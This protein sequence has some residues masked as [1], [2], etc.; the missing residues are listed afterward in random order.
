MR[1]VNWWYNGPIILGCC[2]KRGADLEVGKISTPDPVYAGDVLT[3]TLVVTNNGPSVASGVFLVDPS[4][5]GLSLE[6]KVL[7]HVLIVGRHVL[8]SSNS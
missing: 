3:Y 2:I 1:N 6:S 5:P 4:P 8:L 7:Q